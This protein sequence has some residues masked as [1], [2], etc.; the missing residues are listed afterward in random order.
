MARRRRYLKKDPTMHDVYDVA[1]EIQHTWAVR[2]IWQVELRHERF[3][4][5]CRANFL[6]KHISGQIAAQELKQLEHTAHRGFELVL[7]QMIWA[8]RQQ[9]D[10][11]DHG[12]DGETGERL[13]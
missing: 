11:M 4:V 1:D 6:E 2:V 10:R 13:T 5:L 8:L 9:L 12:R 3:V 7:Y